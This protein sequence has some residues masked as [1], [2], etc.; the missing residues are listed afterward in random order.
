MK[1]PYLV[2]AR[3]LSD[4]R[5]NRCRGV[6]GGGENDGSEKPKRQLAFELQNSVVYEKRSESLKLFSILT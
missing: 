6:G 1:L 5:V 3:N 2:H 4:S